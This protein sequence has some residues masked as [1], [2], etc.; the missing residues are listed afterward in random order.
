MTMRFFRTLYAIIG[1]EALDMKNLEVTNDTSE[2]GYF[3]V[4][5][6]TNVYTVIGPFWLDFGYVGVVVYS[7]IIGSVSGFLYRIALNKELWAVIAY[8]FFACTLVLQFF[9]EYIFTNLSYTIQIMALTF[10]AFKFKYT[11][12]W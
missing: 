5:L 4:P 10:F 9:G 11:F 6:P 12:K 3:F 2:K 1:G 7:F 8:S